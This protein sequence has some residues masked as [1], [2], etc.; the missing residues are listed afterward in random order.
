MTDWD[1]ERYH[2]LSNPQLGWGR[3]VLERLAPEP[4]ERI[5]DL[6]CGTGRLTAELSAVI[7]DGMVVAAD[8]SEA[9]LREAASQ[10]FAPRGPHPIDPTR[11]P[12]RIQFVRA[13]GLHLP[14]VDAFD[15]VLSTAT[16]HWILDHD[17]LFASVYRALVPGGRLVAQCG[18]A[19][20][21]ARLL[22]RSDR[23]R[24]RAPFAQHFRGWRDP[25]FFADVPTTIGRL[26]RAGFTAIEVS[27]EQAPTTLPDRRTY[28]EFLSTVCVREHIARLPET[29]RPEYLEALAVLSDTD[30]PAYTLDYWRLNIQ[31]R[32]PTGAG[33]ERAA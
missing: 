1:A 13:D 8:R 19:G 29:V 14:F 31:A 30:R 33:V 28:K 3:R 16:F 12:Q 22:E 18:G 24:R 21:L 32:K 23:L 5:L 25:W 6:G 10:D 7:R 27:L 2:R 4:N 26:D 17:L 11:P 20:N 9:M 15:A